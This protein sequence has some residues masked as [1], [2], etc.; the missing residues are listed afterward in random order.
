M[1]P[2]LQEILGAVAKL[3]GGASRREIA[4]ALAHVSGRTLLRR[5]RTLVERGA[6]HEEGH[7]N[8]LRYL[9]ATREVPF[10]RSSPIRERHG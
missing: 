3:G 8:K 4:A 6:L 2:E 7:T 9:L 5:L 10:L 1:E